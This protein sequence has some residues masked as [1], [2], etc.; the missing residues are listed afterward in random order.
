MASKVGEMYKYKE[1]NS[2]KEMNTVIWVQMT[3]DPT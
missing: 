3:R 1:T 2:M